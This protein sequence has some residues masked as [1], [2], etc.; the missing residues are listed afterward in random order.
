MY[1]GKKISVAI[2]SYN[3]E[4]FLPQQLDSILSQTVVP[5]EILISDDGSR[6]RTVEIANRYREQFEGNTEI[7]IRTDNP[8]HGIG[9]NFEWA[10]R[11]TTGDFIFI[12]GQDDVL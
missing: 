4:Q 10:I 2:A 9:G 8:C 12:C 6:D 7:I 1:Q 3:G 11:H 5:D